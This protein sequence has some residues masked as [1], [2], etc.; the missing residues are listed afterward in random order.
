MAYPEFISASDFKDRWLTPENAAIAMHKSYD[1]IEKAGPR[2]NPKRVTR[3]VT[4]SEST[5]MG[6]VAE[7]VVAQERGIDCNEITGHIYGGDHG[8]DLVQGGVT[9][10]VKMTEKRGGNLVRNH[11]DTPADFYVLCWPNER[12][13]GATIIGATTHERFMDEHEPMPGGRPGT[14][15]M[16][17]TLI[18][19]DQFVESFEWRQELIERFGVKPRCL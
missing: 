16:W 17:P 15:V 10:D 18:S 13:Y 5:I 7:A 12:R 8:I 3:N 2:A 11:T 1:I 19:W 6:T 4:Q 9:I 14:R